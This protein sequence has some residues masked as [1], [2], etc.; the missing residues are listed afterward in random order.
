MG[1]IAPLGDLQI[2]REAPVPL[3]QH[4][5]RL[6]LHYRARLT[7]DDKYKESTAPDFAI[8]P[9]LRPLVEAQCLSGGVRYVVSGA[10]GVRNSLPDASGPRW[11]S[12]TPQRGRGG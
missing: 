10:E 5:S 3:A 6:E 4:F 7:P 9:P 2:V 8:L 1:C 11:R 12:K